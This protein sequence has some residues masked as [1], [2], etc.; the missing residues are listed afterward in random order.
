VF[1]FKPSRGLSLR[2]MNRS[3]QVLQQE[4]SVDYFKVEKNKELM[5]TTLLRDSCCWSHCAAQALSTRG[6]VVSFISTTDTKYSIQIST[7][8]KFAEC[9]QSGKM[10]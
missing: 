6:Q 5:S 8:T 7:P 3:V 4:A 10:M 1:E 2:S 9:N